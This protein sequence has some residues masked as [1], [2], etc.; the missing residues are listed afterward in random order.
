M[1]EQEHHHHLELDVHKGWKCTLC[2][3]QFPLDYRGERTDTKD[4]AGREVEAALAKYRP[5]VAADI[6]AAAQPLMAIAWDEGY[7]QGGPMHDVNMDDPDAH[8]RNPYRRQE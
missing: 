8:T 4:P 5:N 6:L 3:E 1:T 7:K 2:G